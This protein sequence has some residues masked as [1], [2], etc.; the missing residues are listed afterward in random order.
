MRSRWHFIIR[1]SNSFYKLNKIERKIKFL[2]LNTLKFLSIT[3][4]FSVSVTALVV[5]PN[6]KLWEFC[7]TLRGEELSLT[8]DYRLLGHEWRELKVDPYICSESKLRKIWTRRIIDWVVRHFFIFITFNI[9]FQKNQLL[10]LLHFKVNIKNLIYR[11]AP[12]YIYDLIKLYDKYINYMKY[13]SVY[14]T[15]CPI[16]YIYYKS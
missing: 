13:T 15:I 7:L 5:R 6:I 9:R 8:T 12:S 3:F 11:S 4:P 16:K 10:L 14:S 1:F 2:E